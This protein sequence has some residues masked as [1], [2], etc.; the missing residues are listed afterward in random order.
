MNEST[1]SVILSMPYA[2]AEVANVMLYPMTG[3]K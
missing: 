2:G 1:R 3:K